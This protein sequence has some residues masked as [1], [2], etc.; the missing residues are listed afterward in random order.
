MIERFAQL[1]GHKP[2]VPCIYGIHAA[3]LWYNVLCSQQMTQLQAMAWTSS[4]SV[5]A[6]HLRVQ[7]RMYC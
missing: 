2:T 3:A 1:E 4:T 7:I 5:D 6:A